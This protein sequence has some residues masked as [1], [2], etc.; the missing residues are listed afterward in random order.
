LVL[1]PLL[2]FPLPAQAG[3]RY[4]IYVHAKIVEETGLRNPT[5]SVF[6]V[7]EYD[8]ILDS[9]RQSGFTVLSDQ[10]PSRANSDSFAVRTVTQVDSLIH[11]GVRPEAI[12][13]IGFSKGGWIAILAS[14]KLQNPAVSFVFMGACGPWSND[15]AD[16]HVSGRVLSLHETSDSLGVSCAPLLARAA[17]GSVT[18]ELSLSLGLGHGT[19]YQPRSA[20]LAPVIGWAR[21][22][23]A[24]QDGR[25]PTYTRQLLLETTAATS[26]NVSI[27]DL[28]GDGTLDLVLANWA[29]ATAESAPHTI[30]PPPPLAPTRRGSPISTA[31]ATRTWCSA[32]TRRIPKW[33]T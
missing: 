17:P 27:A 2:P 1:L 21:G 14:A 23:S 8:A 26:A 16:L 18:R 13:V 19:F 25:F 4:V 22:Q 32:T 10:R 28:D 5:D 20:W 9:L 3:P 24:A 30:S 33:S 12:T 6:G 29:T 15:R 11:L 7:Y 31:T